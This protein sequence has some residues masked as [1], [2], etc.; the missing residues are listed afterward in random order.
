MGPRHGP[1]LCLCDCLQVSFSIWWV[2]GRGGGVEVAGPAPVLA[3]LLLG[4]LQQ[5]G[6]RPLQAP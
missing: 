2:S 1:Q 5:G 3:L 6:A 4:L